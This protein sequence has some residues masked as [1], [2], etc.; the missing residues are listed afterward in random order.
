MT[1]T[2]RFNAARPAPK[3]GILDIAPYKP[4]KAA[5]EGVIDPVKLS[6]NENILGCSDSAKAA[7]AE[8]AGKLN[9][10]PDGRANLLRG[11]IAEKYRLEPERLLFGCGSDEIFQLLNQTFLEPGDNMIQGAHGFAAYAIGARACGGEVRYA[12]ESDL[13]IDVDALL[14]Q[15]DDRTRLIFL[16]NPANPTGTWISAEEIRRLHEALPPSVILVLDGAYAEFQSDPAFDDGLGLARDAHNVVVTRTFS[17]IHGLAALRVGW[18][19]MP[20]DMAD[21]VDRIRL[22]FNINIP[23]QMAAIAALK[24]DDFVARSVALVEQW[25]PWLTQQ[26]SGLGLDVVPS[27]ANFVLVGF[28]TIAGKTAVEA[29]AFLAFRGLLTRG[30]GNY[31]LP[32]HLRITIGLEV[33]NRAVVEGLAEFMSR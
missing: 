30:V 21:A 15:V 3:P 20:A 5:A 8:A 18:G 24:D 28:P 23:A 10:Y 26:I 13:R 1:T 9:L 25:R 31:G 17:K 4:G 7:Y 22:P 12:P 2:D 27:A 32:D 14:A 33:H 11:A 29:E 19:Y 16:A 6:A